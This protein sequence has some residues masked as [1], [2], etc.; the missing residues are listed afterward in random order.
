MVA[1][2]APG[3]PPG[4]A[5]DSTVAPE[6]SV[7]SAV[8]PA[9]GFDAGVASWPAAARR[10]QAVADCRGS[11]SSRPTPSAISVADGSPNALSAAFAA[12]RRVAHPDIPRVLGEVSARHEA[13]IALVDGGVFA[14]N[15]AAC[16][17]VEAI[18]DHKQSPDSVIMLSLGTGE[19]RTSYAY[20]RVRDW[21]AVEWARPLIEILLSAGGLNEAIITAV[22]LGDEAATTN[23]IG[24]AFEKIDSFRA[25]ALGGLSACQNRIG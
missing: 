14:N 19:L 23:E 16:A 25:G 13:P 18:V 1:E 21:G 4:A 7:D 24:S 15:P 20:D 10:C 5:V 17:L 11:S 12:L 8:A 9:L 22:A 6:A 3:G 2:A